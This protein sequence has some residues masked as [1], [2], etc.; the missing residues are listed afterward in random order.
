[1]QIQIFGNS[2]DPDQLASSDLALHRF[3]RQEISGF[4]RTCVNSPNKDFLLF[5]KK[6]RL[7]IACKFSSFLS[8]AKMMHEMSFHFLGK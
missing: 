7:D 6:T 8:F 5:S 1:M 4:S 2:V 3:Q